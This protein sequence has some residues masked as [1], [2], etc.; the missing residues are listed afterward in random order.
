MVALGCYACS[1]NQTGAVT[2][3][4]S[5]QALAVEALRGRAKASRILPF[6]AWPAGSMA[7]RARMRAAALGFARLVLMR[8]TGGQAIGLC[9]K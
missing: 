5:D 4:S 3:A 2:F 6:I 7:S 9:L 1:W 8:V